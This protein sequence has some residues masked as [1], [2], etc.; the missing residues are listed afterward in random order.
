VVIPTYNEADN[1]VKL[2]DEVFASVPNRYACHVLV[3]DDSSPD[4]TA[5]RVEEKS[6][7]DGRVGLL[8]RKGKMGLGGAY[9]DGFRFLWESLDPDFYVQM[10]ADFS[11]PPRFL[12]ALLDAA[13]EGGCVSIGSR[14]VP[15][16]GIVGC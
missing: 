5:A 9:L 1:I 7:L 8:V 4:G 13:V 16:G 6:N 12:P 15:G 10:D 11:H 2:I 14:R 3:V